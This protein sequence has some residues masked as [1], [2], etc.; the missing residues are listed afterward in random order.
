L[1]AKSIGSILSFVL[2]VFVSTG[3]CLGQPDSLLHAQKNNIKKIVQWE[4]HWGDIPPDSTGFSLFSSVAEHD[5]LWSKAPE[6]LLPNSGRNGLWLR[7]KLPVWTEPAPAVFINMAQQEMTVFCDGNMIFDNANYIRDKKDGEMLGFRWYLIKLNERCPGK[8]LY[9]HFTSKSKEIGLAAPIA[10]GPLDY[11]YQEII[12]GNVYDLIMGSVILLAAFVMLAMFLFVR[13]TQFYLGLA[14]FFFA[15]SISVCFDNPYIYLLIRDTWF[16]VFVNNFVYFFF[17]AIFVSLEEMVLPRFQIIVRRVWQIHA[18]YVAF[19][20][21]VLLL[22]SYTVLDL[23]TPFLI[24]QIVTSNLVVFFLIRSLSFKKVDHVIL[25]IG[26]T[27]F[28]ILSSI[29]II[30]YYYYFLSQTEALVTKTFVMHWGIFQFVISL[31]AVGI[32]RYVHEEKQ[33]RNAEQKLVQQQQLALEAQQREIQTHERY[34]HQLLQSQDNERKRIAMELH[35]AVGQELLII[36]NMASLCIK[37]KS[38][39]AKCESSAEYLSEISTASSSVIESVRT[40]SKN[41]HPYQLDSLGL[42][43]ALESLVQRVEQKSSIRFEYS[44]ENIDGV[45]SREHELHLYRIVQEL[46]NNILKHSEATQATIRVST[47]DHFVKLSVSDNGKG[48]FDTI[49]DADRSASKFGFGISGIQE[50][51]SILRGTMAMD[52]EA[53]KG[54]SIQITIPRNGNEPI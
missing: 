23:K 18:G 30:N 46:L 12:S 5:T 44:F 17:A 11:F 21:V 4:A 53:S 52:S 49:R 19:A 28:S 9:F 51:V 45:F 24:L 36:K 14:I 26:T 7:T 10:I 20:V 15:T 40:L 31:I 35:D 2:I 34:T 3:L 39:P 29:E 48:M 8:Y 32:Y 37:A 22:T 41:L 47:A 38:D 50:R 54:T 16:V 6:S 43:D 33:T 25:V 13:T 42:S 27:V 1:N